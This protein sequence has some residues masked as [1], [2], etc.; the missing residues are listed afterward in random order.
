MGVAA[1]HEIG[2]AMESLFGGI[3]MDRCQGTGM[4]GIEGI[5][6]SSRFDSADF[7]EDD[8]VRSP[9]QS[10]LQKIIERDSGLEGIG[11]AF[12][13][14]NI[15]L[16][17]AKLRRILDDDDAL[18]LRNRLGQDVEKSRLPAPGST[19]D[20][21]GLSVA[22]LLAQEVRESPGQRAASDQV[23]DGIIAGW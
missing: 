23:I 20:K 6:Q 10:R 2:E 17:D 11:L 15:R 7:A 9:A 8:P 5:E 22:N 18:L 4:A 14:Q 13:G 1:H 19:A 3:G 21:Q 16:L 12:D